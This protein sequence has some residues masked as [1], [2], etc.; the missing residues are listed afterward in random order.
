MQSTLSQQTENLKKFMSD[1]TDVD[2]VSEKEIIHTYQELIDCLTD[3]NH[4][5]YI[6]NKPIISD[7]EYDELF[8]Y[9]KKI[10]EHYPHIISSNSPTQELIGQIAEGFKQ[11]P[12]KNKLLSLENT[13]NAEDILEWEKRIN[14][15]LEKQENIQPATYAVTPKF[16]GISVELIYKDKKF[17]KAITRGDGAVGEDITENVK[18]IFSIPKELK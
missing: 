9:L 5:Y 4:L 18:M 12:H 2:Q 11:A 1:H 7:L 15:E 3:H 8:S 6:E 13:Y 10:E 14:K 17:Y 16:D